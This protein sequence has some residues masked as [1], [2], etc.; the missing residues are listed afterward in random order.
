VVPDLPADLFWRAGSFAALWPFA[1][2]GYFENLLGFKAT[3]EQKRWAAVIHASAAVLAIAIWIIHVY[4]AIWVRDTISAMTRGT[5]SGAQGSG[6]RRDRAAARDGR[7]VARPR[8]SPI[9]GSRC[10][11]LRSAAHRPVK[12]LYQ[13]RDPALEPLAD[14]V[15]TSASIC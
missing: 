15:A 3:I 10:S 14:D 13:V 2:L 12:I 9:L 8:L 11:C 7:R 5:V 6:Q 4:A 1:G